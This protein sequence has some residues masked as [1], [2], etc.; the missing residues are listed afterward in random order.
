MS[1]LGLPY[2]QTDTRL[3]FSGYI[4]TESSLNK[5]NEIQ[6]VQHLII[7]LDPAVLV[8]QVKRGFK[9]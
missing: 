3:M 1:G 5:M 4:Q 7:V 8:I 9:G 2:I 6:Q